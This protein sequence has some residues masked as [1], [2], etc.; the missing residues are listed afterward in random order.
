MAFTK[1]KGLVTG[2][3]FCSMVSV[4]LFLF[5]PIPP[6]GL[7]AAI[8]LAA[9]AA[10]LLCGLLFPS[11][12]ERFRQRVSRALEKEPKTNISRWVP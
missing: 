8:D 11:Q 10:L 1:P 5:N 4:G 9:M 3:T 12:V 6:V 2:V 7:V